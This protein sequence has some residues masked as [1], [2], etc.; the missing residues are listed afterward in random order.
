MGEWWA[1]LTAL[2]K[3]L[4][5]VAIPSTL[6]F[7]LQAI[8]LLIGIGEGGSGIDD[9]DFDVDADIPDSLDDGSNPL[10][11]DTFRLFSVQSVTALL[12]VFGWTAVAMLHHDCSVPVTM[13]VAIVAGIVMMLLVSWLIYVMKGLAQNGT[14]ELTSALGASGTV[15]IRI[16]AKGQGVGKVNVMLQGQ[17][18]ELDAVTDEEEA[19]PTNSGVRVVD[20]RNNLLVVESE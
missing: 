5:I 11:F 13:L 4:Y 12:C 8:L 16:P 2:E 7:I 17:L 9:L 3:A 15:Y 19:I 6:I 10:D 14:M 18:Q 20:V 1:A